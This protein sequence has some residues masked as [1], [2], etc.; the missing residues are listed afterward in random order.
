V[1]LPKYRRPKNIDGQKTKYRE[2][3][4]KIITAGLSLVLQKNCILKI[5]VQRGL[6]FTVLFQIQ[7][8][9]V[10]VALTHT[11]N[12]VHVNL[13]MRTLTANQ[14]S[15]AIR[16][17]GP[18]L[19]EQPGN[20]EVIFFVESFLS[21]V[22]F[23]AASLFTVSPIFYFSVYFYISTERR[24]GTGASASL[25]EKLDETCVKQLCG[26][27][28]SKVEFD[29]LANDGFIGKTQF[30]NLVATHHDRLHT[31]F[32]E[33]TDIFTKNIWE[34]LLKSTYSD[35][36]FNVDFGKKK[37]QERFRIALYTTATMF[38]LS[39]TFTS[40]YSHLRVCIDR[41]FLSI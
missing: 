31:K 30:L 22:L 11:A 23:P 18:F 1:R 36:L 24:M 26:I 3:I 25:P 20:P 35:V 15:T 34:P 7:R 39:S 8:A 32:C 13:A 27:H 10:C 29:H 28:F 38:V 17:A 9:N 14:K 12:V 40:L 2:K 19:Q 33:V 16:L 6:Y 41:C 37:T 21:F 5:Q 4:R